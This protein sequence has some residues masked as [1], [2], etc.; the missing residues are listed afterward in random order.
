MALRLEDKQALVEEVN[1]IAASA[2]SA[3]EAEYR[4]SP[5]CGPRPAVR[6]STSVWSRTPSPNEP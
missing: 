3:I 6:V 2:L 1:A 5:S 4:R